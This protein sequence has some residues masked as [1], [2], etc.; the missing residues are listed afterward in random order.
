MYNIHTQYKRTSFIAILLTIAITVLA[1]PAKRGIWQQLTLKDGTTVRAE[2]RGDES[3]HY[4]LTDDGSYIAD[5]GDGYA[6]VEDVDAWKQGV[7]SKKK[8]V[9]NRAKKLLLFSLPTLVM[10]IIYK[11]NTNEIN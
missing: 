2:L 9:R 5:Q 3:F 6:K 4:W 1:V 11:V 8:G 7:R 10:L